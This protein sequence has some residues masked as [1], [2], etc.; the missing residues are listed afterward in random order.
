M[1]GTQCREQVRCCDNKDAAQQN[2]VVDFHCQSK[3]GEGRTPAATPYSAMAA[4]APAAAAVDARRPPYYVDALHSAET[5][6]EGEQAVREY[7]S[8]HAAWYRVAYADRLHEA[9]EEQVR[10]EAQ[11]HGLSLDEINEYL[12]KQQHI[13]PFVHR[14]LCPVNTES[15]VLALLRFLTASLAGGF[16]ALPCTT[17]E[18]RVVAVHFMVT[19][20]RDV[21]DPEVQ[22]W[23]L[24][25][26]P[27]SFET[28]NVGARQLEALGSMDNG[29]ADLINF[30]RH[31]LALALLNKT[32]DRGPTPWI[33]NIGLGKSGKP[34]T[35]TVLVLEKST[36]P[37]GKTLRQRLPRLRLNPAAARKVFVNLA[38]CLVHCARSGVA[39]SRFRAEEVIV[40]PG[41]EYI[42]S[43]DTRLAVSY[44]V[45]DKR[46]LT[47]EIAL[48]STFWVPPERTR[49]GYAYVLAREYEPPQ[50]NAQTPLWSFGMILLEYFVGPSVQRAYEMGDSWLEF[51]GFWSFDRHPWQDNKVMS[52][53]HRWMM[54]PLPSGRVPIG[55]VAGWL[56]ELSTEDFTAFIHTYV[57]SD[58][59]DD[60][61]GGAAAAAPVT[62]ASP[63]L[64]SAAEV[65][66]RSV[67]PAPTLSP[68]G[69]V[70]P[71]DDVVPASLSLETQTL[72]AE[73]STAHRP[74]KRPRFQ[75]S[76][77]VP[78]SQL[79]LH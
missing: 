44:T 9:T 7:R 77:R 8:D 74:L 39:A 78:V 67:S 55:E 17:Y 31:S 20:E 72:P 71:A 19:N 60:S 13:P 37:G 45:I 32:T 50:Y 66:P 68:P 52:Y 15:E 54:M 28:W 11:M 51:K 36:V 46:E 57:P 6:D 64:F 18:E 65:A 30:L 27:R 63:E 4:A 1:L 3:S 5:S 25:H 48:R 43:L 41:P 62:P 56:A 75:S 53:V 26:T 2:R 14:L 34:G 10:H 23:P 21:R 76:R 38:R 29:M 33:H 79:R 73:W 61:G 42:V 24:A 22:T 40:G 59:D 12:Q 47:S 70:P 49:K 35:S 58:S 16:V 69:A